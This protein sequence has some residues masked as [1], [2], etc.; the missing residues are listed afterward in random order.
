MDT[1]I[2]SLYENVEYWYE[3]L[4]IFNIKKNIVITTIESEHDI[5][6]YKTI[7]YKEEKNILPT[8]ADYHFLK[9]EN[10]IILPN[11]NIVYDLDPILENEFISIFPNINKI[12]GNIM[13]KNLKDQPIM[14]ICS[15]KTKIIPYLKCG[16]V[17]LY[18]NPA[19]L[20]T[21]I[22]KY[23]NNNTK[24][25][26]CDKLDILT[27]CEEDYF[28]CKNISEL[29]YYIDLH[30]NNPDYMRISLK[31]FNKKMDLLKKKVIDDFLI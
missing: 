14:V 22:D 7:S 18:Y 31:N 4:K 8:G 13:L 11:V 9:L 20:Y 16:I 12:E 23:L 17:F 29:R 15:D 2:I 21:W 24:F 30:Y 10:K 5:N 3:Y 27:I 28:Y 1:K 25:L 26:Y 19:I 6:K